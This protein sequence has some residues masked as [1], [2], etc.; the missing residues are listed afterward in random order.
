MNAEVGSEEARW[1][2]LRCS[3]SKTL[4]LAASLTEDG[5]EAWTPAEVVVKG[6]STGPEPDLVRRA[7]MA[8]WVFARAACLQDLLA[9]SRSP[10][11]NYQ[12]WDSDRRKMVTKGHPSFRLF[13]YVG[14]IKTIPDRQLTALRNLERKRQ[15][16][17]K[18]EPLEPGVRV[19]L[20][21]AGFEGLWATVQ[22]SRKK[23]TIALVDGWM[24][25][26]FPTY[27]LRQHLDGSND[28][29]VEGVKAPSAK[30]A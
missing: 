26:T 19:R 17:P 29:G 14:E 21:E 7:L 13:R 15:P 5:F 16:R 27:S 11:L 9:L 6:G 4:D 18:V 22:V 2:I 30:A 10:S 8:S 23:E 3:S 12:V 28:G 25:V 20:Q 1:C 24:P